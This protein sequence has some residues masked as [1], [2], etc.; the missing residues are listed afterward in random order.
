MIL[1]LRNPDN[2]IQGSRNIGTVSSLPEIGFAHNRFI[3]NIGAPVEPEQWGDV[4]EEVH[5]EA[6]DDEGESVPAGDQNDTTAT[7]ALA[8]SATILFAITAVLIYFF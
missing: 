4:I 5:E 7:F 2:Y 8:V 6:G 1:N 3:G